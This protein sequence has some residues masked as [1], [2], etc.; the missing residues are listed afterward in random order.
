MRVDPLKVKRKTH[1]VKAL[2]VV[3]TPDELQRFG[4]N[5]NS[6]FFA[7]FSGKPLGIT[8]TRFYTA[9]GQ[10]PS[11]ATGDIVYEQ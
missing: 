1:F 4:R 5:T 6:K 2:I 8:F 9:T 11:A 7:N 10:R 3:V